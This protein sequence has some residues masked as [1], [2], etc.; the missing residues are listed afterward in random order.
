[1]IEIERYKDEIVN[2][3]DPSTILWQEPMTLHTSFKI[4]GPAD[5]FF[6]PQSIEDLTAMIDLC[7]KSSIPF[8][9]MGN[10]SNLLVGDQGYRGVIIQV[11]RNLSSFSIEGNTVEAEA[12]ILLSKL[13]NRVYDA[14][15]EGFEFASGIPGTLGGAVYM[16]AG[17]YGGEMK[18]IIVSAKVLTQGGDVK[19]LSNEALELGYRHSALMN[20]GDIV[21]ST[22]MVLVPGEQKVI[23]AKMDELNFRRKDKQPV[24]KPSAG[25]T[26]K[27]PVG[28]YAGKLIMDAGLRGYQLGGARVSDKHCGFVINTGNATSK[29]V[30]AL[31][32][33]IQREVKNQF[34]VDLEPEVRM[35]GDF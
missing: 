29:D 19:T 6:K 34:G 21:L 32:Q 22:K 16:N 5:L 7:Q 4:G 23:R 20:E 35:I 28:Y 10:G 8:Y 3:F 11:Y 26:F 13:A 24:E 1:M 17:A 14:G 18:D 9:I 33:H 12:G 15:L 25:S 31:I 30:M 2:R 27:R